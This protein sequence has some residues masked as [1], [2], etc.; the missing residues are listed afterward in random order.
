MALAINTTTTLPVGPN[1]AYVITRP[2]GCV[3]STTSTDTASVYFDTL[4]LGT[5][6]TAPKGVSFRCTPNPVSGGHCG[7]AFNVFG[8]QPVTPAVFGAGVGVWTHANGLYFDYNGS[9]YVEAWHINPGTSQASGAWLDVVEAGS[10][11][12]GH[13]YQVD[14]S[15]YSN[16]EYVFR[17]LD[18]GYK[19]DAQS[20]PHLH[21]MPK[22]YSSNASASDPDVNVRIRAKSVNG[23]TASAAAFI[24]GAGTTMAVTPIAIFN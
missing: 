20:M 5:L 15:L 3:P 14:A 1:T 12:A 4:N 18:L 17:V 22:F 21:A 10:W 19:L 7:F 9:I 2:A 8:N 16:G 6:G 13:T 24:A 11:I 23:R